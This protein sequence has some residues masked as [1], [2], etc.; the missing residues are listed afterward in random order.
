MV[1]RSLVIALI[2]WAGSVSGQALNGSTLRVTSLEGNMKANGSSLVTAD[3]LELKA[4]TL[5]ADNELYVRDSTLLE[6]IAAN[7]AETT[8]G[9][10]D[11][12][13]QFNDAGVFGGSADL[14][15]DGTS[16]TVDNLNLNLNTIS[17]TTGEIYLSS[18]VA[19]SIAATRGY[20]D[21][22]SGLGLLAANNLSDVAN[23]VTSREN[24]G[25]YTI[26]NSLSPYNN[27][28]GYQTLNSNTSGQLNNAFGYQAL[29][30]N[31]TGINN[32]AFG[33]QAL[34]NNT[35]GNYNTGFGYD[36]GRSITIGSYNT[37]IGNVT[38]IGI[39]TGSYNTILGANVTGL[40]AALTNNIILSDGQNVELQYASGAWD[41]KDNALTDISSLTV[42]N[43]TLNDST[44]TSSGG[45]VVVD[46][47]L[48]VTGTRLNIENA[49]GAGVRIKETGAVNSDWIIE[50]P[51]GVNH[52][53]FY[54]VN[55]ASNH[56]EINGSG[57]INIQG[58]YDETT[59]SAANVFVDTDGSLRRSTAVNPVESGATV[60]TITNQ[61]GVTISSPKVLWNKVSNM[62]NF[63]IE[64]DATWSSSGVKSFEFSLPVASNLA[65]GDGVAV[66]AGGTA[67]VTRVRGEPDIINDTME[68]F[69]SVSTSSGATVVYATGMYEI[70]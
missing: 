52:L 53:N 27:A 47:D 18:A 69:F 14:T 61:T 34:Y 10:S 46:D 32:N 38:G 51:N 17:A 37:A 8:P 68:I 48:D 54:H 45:T 59:A 6:I 22:K 64:V 43:L 23:S 15:W 67:A 62:V 21:T 70:N 33:Y 60:P 1:S 12:Q 65:S 41:V 25:L 39:T 13:V 58:V 40:S 44:I 30:N 63:T 20:V 26:Q 24:L 3:T 56:I 36:A 57:Q 50:T 31:T 42:D 55:S 35:T 11:T 49:L 16:L 19:D 2:L 9:G 66:G 29:F 28:F 7:A 4:D 5:I